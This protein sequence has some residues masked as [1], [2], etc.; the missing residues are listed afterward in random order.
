MHIRLGIVAVIALWCAN[1]AAQESLQ[2]VRFQD[3]AGGCLSP[4]ESYPYKLPKDDPLYETAREDHQR[5]LEELEDYVNCLDQ[6][7]GTA[8]AEL[9][10]SF[11]LFMENFGRDAVLKYANER[12]ARQ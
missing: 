5:Y 10:A 6:E 9:R 7:R 2:P 3:T 12:E 1:A 4:V 11:N 8:L